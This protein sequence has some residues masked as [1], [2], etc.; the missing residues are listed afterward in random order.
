MARK[1]VL[2]EGIKTIEDLRQNTHLL[3]KNQ[4]ICLQYFE[5]FEQR[6]P[7]DEI[8]KVVDIVKGYGKEIDSDI[9]IKC[10]GS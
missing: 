7:R 8:S 9:L 1:L 5:D 3:T 10:C 4:K 6:I 2:E